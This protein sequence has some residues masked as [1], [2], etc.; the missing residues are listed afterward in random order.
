MNIATSLFLRILPQSARSHHAPRVNGCA[1]R[2]AWS[3][4]FA[5]I[6]L[7][8]IP[9]GIVA[10]S[11]Y[12]ATRA[13]GDS[14]D[15]LLARFSSHQTAFE[16][17]PQMLDSDRRTLALGEGPMDLAHLEAAGVGNDYRA[18]LA[19]IGASDLRYF[20]RSGE[21][22]LLLAGPNDRSFTSTKR[23]YLYSSHERPPPATAHGSYFGPGIYIVTEDHPIQGR[24]FIH[25]ERVVSIA[26]ARF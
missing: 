5:S 14:D 19:E 3:E 18:L 2:P 24:W 22:V 12:S 23:S 21:I 11:G 15:E 25:H 4:R 16:V 9:A 6:L 10:L 13:T 7:V 1:E 8:A 26:F 20:P 17:L